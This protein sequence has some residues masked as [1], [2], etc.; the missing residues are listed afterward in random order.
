MYQIIPTEKFERDIKYYIKKKGFK[1]ITKDIKLITD[2][3][4]RGNLVGKEVSGLTIKPDGHTFKVRAANTD[5][6][7][8]KS[9]GYRILYYV[10][11]NDE[12]I[13]LLTIYYKKEDNRM[14]TNQ[15]I[16][17]LIKTYCI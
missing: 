2:E 6:K 10:V 16:I 12:E 11:K 7:A 9:N 13:Y 17:E 5:T 3:L 4:E 8:G 15:E 14:P 1:K